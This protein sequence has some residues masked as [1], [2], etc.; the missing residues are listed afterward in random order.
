MHFYGVARSGAPNHAVASLEHGAFKMELSAPTIVT[1]NP[2]LIAVR[3]DKAG[4]ACMAIREQAYQKL[5][6]FFWQTTCGGVPPVYN[7]PSRRGAPLGDKR[8]SRIIAAAGAACSSRAVSCQMLRSMAG[9]YA[10]PS[11]ARR[12]YVMSSCRASGMVWA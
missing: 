6:R 4:R 12:T 10:S 7:A 5:C 3:T 2:E 1:P 8:K 9:K 11:T